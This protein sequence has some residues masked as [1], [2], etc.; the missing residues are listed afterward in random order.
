[1]RYVLAGFI[2]MFASYSDIFLFR[3]GINPVTPS[4]LVIPMFIVCGFLAY[5]IK[6]LLTSMKT[7]SFKLLALILFL[8]LVYSPVSKA[9]STVIIEKISLNAITLLMYLVAVHF[10]RTENAKLIRL[11]LIASVVVLGGSVIYDFLVGL[12][13]FGEATTSN[14]RK[15]GFGEN[16][17]QAATGIKFLTLAALVYLTEKVKLRYLTI[18]VMFLSVFLTFSRSGLLSIVLI[19]AMG[20]M[21]NWQNNFQQSLSSMLSRSLKMVAFFLML[22]VLLLA[23]ADAIRANFPQF[24]RGDAGKRLDL[25]TGQIDKEDFEHQATEGGRTDLVFIYLD[26]FLAYPFGYGTGHSSDKLANGN[27]LN[28]HNYFLYLGI[29]LGIVAIFSYLYYLVLS[30]RLS[31][32]HDQYFYFVFAMLFALEGIFTHNL[33]HERPIIICLA[34]FD[35]TIYRRMQE[36]SKAIDRKITNNSNILNAHL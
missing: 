7:H 13:V 10:F 25:L 29:N 27:K 35:G 24:T 1:M 20:V 19:M 6:Q 21:N 26:E 12:P 18:A 32:K 22:F 5:P 14:V 9:S 16:P 28:T 4:K 23:L 8:S 36:V 2:V 31:I 34:L 15:G 30:M 17:N 3:M 11:T 33:L